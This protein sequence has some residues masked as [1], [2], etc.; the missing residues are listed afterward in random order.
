MLH[1]KQHS[2]FGLL[3]LTFFLLFSDPSQAETL[4][5]VTLA[6]EE[7]RS[8]FSIKLRKDKLSVMHGAGMASVSLSDLNWDEIELLPEKLRKKIQKYMK[9]EGLST[10]GGSGSLEA[11]VSNESYEFS[12]LDVENVRQVTYRPPILSFTHS[13]GIATLSV[14][15]ISR[16]EIDQLPD[17]IQKKIFEL[18]FFQPHPPES[19]FSESLDI[20]GEVEDVSQEL[21]SKTGMMISVDPL[22]E[23]ITYRTGL[24]L[25]L[26][27][28]EGDNILET[29]NR[30]LESAAGQFAFIPVRENLFFLTTHQALDIEKGLLAFT[31]QDKKGL[32]DLEEILD[33]SSNP[34]ASH[35]LQGSEFLS[36]IDRNISP[37]LNQ[38]LTAIEQTKKYIAKINSL[39]T[40]KLSAATR[41]KGVSASSMIVD[42]SKA[43]PSKP[44][45]ETLSRQAYVNRITNDQQNLITQ[46]NSNIKE[47][48]RSI[49][50][51]HD[52][53]LQL[54]NS[55]SFT[56][57]CKYTPTDVSEVVLVQLK[58]QMQKAAAYWENLATLAETNSD[59]QQDFKDTSKAWLRVREQVE[60]SSKQ[61]TEKRRQRPDVTNHLISAAPAIS[62]DNIADTITASDPTYGNLYEWNTRI[63]R[64]LC[65]LLSKNLQNKELQEYVSS[66]EKIRALHIPETFLEDARNYRPERP[67]ISPLLAYQDY[68]VGATTGLW[69]NVR[70]NGTQ[71]GST[72]EYSAT[73]SAQKPTGE[74][75]AEQY[76]DIPGFSMPSG[77]Y[78]SSVLPKED[79]YCRLSIRNAALWTVSTPCYSQKLNEVKK[80]ASGVKGKTNAI[81][82]L[83]LNYERSLGI[84]VGGDSAGITWATAILS[85]LSGKP[86]NRHVAMT[87]TISPSGTIGPVG[88]IPFKIQ[89]AVKAG[90]VAVLIP[91]SNQTDL[92]FLPASDLISSQIFLTKNCND[93]HKL[94]LAEKRGAAAPI[95]RISLAYFMAIDHL[96]NGNQDIAAGILD[97][98]LEHYPNHYSAKRIRVAIPSIIK[99][100]P[101][102]GLGKWITL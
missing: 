79:I 46:I 85:S 31:G 55:D 26:K 72:T 22:V 56:S 59:I 88:G 48:L 84:N 63:A 99:P 71:V 70:P 25:N 10:G 39:Q 93:V 2:A 86:S 35:I 68:T 80:A 45:E 34:I 91:E 16:D 101:L 9:K 83:V 11:K 77:F 20:H 38:C 65:S 29:L 69:I 8:V 98:I 53:I 17:S 5:S 14:L 32:Y 23:G 64:G 54:I 36:E 49:S 102:D 95:D 74:S 87:G 12:E 89:A 28:S 37:P 43:D 73:L 18:P 33:K 94:V 24:S 82:Y 15:N 58:A 100:A 50:E 42:D 21:F 6:G 90:K 81:P 27:A 3:L 7:Y 66:K 92:N 1:L 13:G 60:A 62:R 67:S 51:V 4:D 47:S 61:A 76:K 44:D 19:T 75:L 96:R 30:S 40:Q 57:F 97:T 78:S 52:R 41:N